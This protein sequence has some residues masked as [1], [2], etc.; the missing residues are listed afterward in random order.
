MS[1]DVVAEVFYLQC[2]TDGRTAVRFEYFAPSSLT[3]NV[4]QVPVQMLIK[5]LRGQEKNLNIDVQG[6]EVAHYEGCIQEDFEPGSD[7][8]RIAYEEVDALLKERLGASRV[9]IFHHAFRF[10]NAALGADKLNRTHRNPA[11]YI[12]TD[13][14]AATV[15]TIIDE[16]FDKEQGSELKKKR[17]QFINIWRPVGPNPVADK[18]LALCDYRSIDIKNDVHTMINHSRNN[19]YTAYTLSRNAKDAHAWYYLSA[20]RSDEM[21]IFKSYDSKPNVTPW[22]AHTAF[23]IPTTFSSRDEQKSLEFRCLVFYDDDDDDDAK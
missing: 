20:M 21:F 5:D 10:R 18:P 6:F 12:H 16:N 14:D 9:F 22:A 8:Q 11:L 15:N 7:K 2:T 4:V 3:S 17:I 1:V 23:E 13:A 19:N